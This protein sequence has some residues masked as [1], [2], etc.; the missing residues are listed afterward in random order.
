MAINVG[1][2]AANVRPSGT[3]G[4]GPSSSGSTSMPTE[5]DLTLWE[6]APL[7]LTR[8]CVMVR[9]YGNSDTGRTTLAFTAPGPIAYI[10]SFEKREGILQRKA[11][12]TLVREHK[13]QEA[14]AG[15]PDQAQQLAHESMAGVERRVSDAYTW[16]RSIILDTDTALWD[17]CQLARLGS[18]VRADRS[19][20][21]NRAGQLIYTE[22]NQRWMRLIKEFNYRA[23]NPGN[24][25]TTN[26]I[27]I[28]STGDEYKGKDR[29]GR[30]IAK[31]QKSL[32]QSCDVVVRTDYTMTV[33]IIGQPPTTV[34]HATI[35][36]PWYEASARGVRVSSDEGTLSFAGIMTTITGDP[37]K[38]EK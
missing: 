3:T 37:D 8:R 30:T 28:G 22:I 38:W 15:T 5:P 12:E 36:K 13:F 23:D 16:A 10:N 31:G 18:L 6:D 21:D 32:F 17:L 9:I 14:F 4:A 27:L 29:T 11:A 26:L 34:Y 19:E 2:A 20:K 33:P 7:E 25:S 24:P 35:E 1:N